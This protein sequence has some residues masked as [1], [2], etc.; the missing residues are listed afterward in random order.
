MARLVDTTVRRIQGLDR[1]AL[2]TI[3][4][5]GGVKV[6]GGLSALAVSVV[7]ARNLGVGE[8]GKFSYYFA[9]A[10]TICF[11]FLLG[12]PTLIIREISRARSE[13]CEP[14]ARGILTFSTLY[15]MIFS[16]S[17]LLVVYFAKTR[18][19]GEPFS[20]NEYYY[21]ALVPLLA[22]LALFGAA[23][24]GLGYVLTNQVIN[25]VLAPV[26]FLLALL[27]WI[28]V[29]DNDFLYHDAILVNALVIFLILIACIF[30]VVR[31]FPRALAGT[32]IQFEFRKWFT[33]M[34]YLGVGVAAS[35]INAQADLLMLGW[36]G[37]EKDVG[38][39]RVAS[40]LAAMIVV[41]LGVANSVLAPRYSKLA[42]RGEKDQLEGVVKSAVLV[43]FGIASSVAALYLFFGEQLILGLFGSDFR[44]AHSCLAILAVG[45]FVAASMGP[46]GY[47]LNMS[48]NER[49]TAYG[50][51][52]ASCMN[53]V[54]NLILIPVYGAIGASIA[55][56]MSLIGWNLL[57]HRAVVKKL[58]IRSD[59]WRALRFGAKI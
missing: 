57:L 21:L 32:S 36:M 54:F 11:P 33:S 22:L 55:F 52:V 25:V 4:Y 9:L 45:Y 23:L 29:N 31:A 10:S 27:V 40:Q 8:Y 59:V 53:I 28:H 6:F 37:S 51:L 34:M 14:V 44:S 3:L 7:L 1:D 50:L 26:T 35:T 15:A 42:A 24:T 5:A 46:V 41:G 56:V 16:A 12:L 20:I 19:F 47:L 38:I 18:Y 48:G 2:R 39:Y 49:T 43:S 58:G 30:F 13:H 17:V